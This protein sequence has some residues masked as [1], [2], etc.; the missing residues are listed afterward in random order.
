MRGRLPES[1]GESRPSRAAAAVVVGFLSLFL[2]PNT[3]WGLGG[4][5][6]LE[7]ILGSDVSLP[8]AL[9][10][11]QEVAIVV[12]IVIV[13]GRA[14][15]WR[16]PLPGWVYSMGIWSMAT[17]FSAVGLYNLFGDNTDQA[18]FV[19]A[20]IAIVMGVLCVVVAVAGRRQDE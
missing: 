14:G 15:I 18:R 20:P 13:L 1:E 10:W 4:T 5:W 7:W 11:A 16:P 2:V 9:V 17:V 3:Y 6:G 19:F 12:G 8:L